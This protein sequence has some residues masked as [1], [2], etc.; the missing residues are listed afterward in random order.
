MFARGKDCPA[1]RVGRKQPSEISVGTSDG[2]GWL[3]AA[4]RFEA[5][6]PAMRSRG[7]SLTELLAVLVILAILA[8]LGVSSWGSASGHAQRK[9]AEAV[10]ES[11]V[12]AERSFEFRY[13]TFADDVALGDVIDGPTVPVAG[14]VA[15]AEGQ[16]SVD[17]SAPGVVG[18]ATVAAEGSCLTVRLTENGSVGRVRFSPS[19][20]RPCSGAQALL[21]MP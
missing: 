11:A 14:G 20:V 2:C 21:E 16:V 6:V 18:L 15:A 10:L 17:V 12:A 1:S 7:F 5:T 13:G 4:G 3:V 19:E 9:K 8:A